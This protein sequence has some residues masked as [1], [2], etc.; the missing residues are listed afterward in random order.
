M[1]SM[2]MIPRKV[3]LPTNWWSTTART[4]SHG[5][6]N[7]TTTLLFHLF[8]GLE[9]WWKQTLVL[10]ERAIMMTFADASSDTARYIILEV[11]V[12]SLMFAVLN[13]EIGEV[14]TAMLSGQWTLFHIDVL[15][16]LLFLWISISCWSINIIT[17]LVIKAAFWNVVRNLAHALGVNRHRFMS[18]LRHSEYLAHLRRSWSGTIDSTSKPT[19]LDDSI[20][21]SKLLKIWM[22]ESLCSRHS[23]IMVIDQKLCNDVTSIWVLRHHLWKTRTFLVGEVKLHMT[24]HLLEL[25]EQF[26][27]WSSNYI[28]DFMN[29]IKLIGT[30]KKRSQS[31]YLEENTADAPVV[32]LVVIVTIGQEALRWPIPPCR[33]IL[34]KWRFR[35]DASTWSKICQLNSISWDQ[36]VFRLNISMINTVS[37]HMIYCLKNLVHHLFDSMLWQRSSLTFDSLIHVHVHQLENQS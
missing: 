11:T 1:R 31:K 20:L 4:S 33:N 12:E 30:W 32:H 36:N 23:M 14:A 37:M 9:N 27:I 13:F 15:I 3:W 10:H 7:T 29:L 25:I 22:L 17:V 26:S 8:V 35:I 19:F 24:C 16:L 34:S 18:F 2:S 21:L 5:A 28:V 6:H